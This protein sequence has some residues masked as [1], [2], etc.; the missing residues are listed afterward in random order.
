MNTPEWVKNATFYHIYPLGLLNA[1][2]TNPKDG[3]TSNRLNMLLPWLDHI[4]SLGL[5]A[6]YM[7]PLFESESHGYDTRDYF[8]VDRRLGS[9][10][11]LTNF[12]H[13]IHRR[14][15][16]IILDGVFNHSGRSFWA[17]EDLRLKQQE[18]QYIDW[19]QDL[20]F[21][22]SNSLGDPFQYQTWNGYSSL[23]KF[24]LSNANVRNYLIQAAHFWIDTFHID[25]LRLDAADQV[26]IDFWEQLR[27][28]LVESQPE[29][30]LMGEIVH[31]D[32]RLWAND[33]HL[34]SVTNYEAHKGLYSSFNDANFFE[35]AYTFNR[36]FGTEGIYRDLWLYN[37]VDNHDVDR[38]ASQLK[39]KNHLFP[40]YALLF[41]MP[42][43]PSIYYGSEWGLPGKRT[44]A[45]DEALRPSLDIHYIPAELT[46]PGLTDAIR[47]FVDIRQTHPAL[48]FGK[49]RQAL[50]KSHQFGFWREDQNQSVLVIINSANEPV[51]VTDLPVPQHFT[52]KDPFN[53]QDIAQITSEKISINIPPCWLRMIVFD[54]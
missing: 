16:H 19:Y 23:P 10:E 12:C 40:L 13:E 9:N 26:P 3:A 21:G 20:R 43:I 47:R 33:S 35:I 36:Q 42:G 51:Q 2:R 53:E 50:V 4:Q 54:K 5:N 22:Q 8:N 7:G 24:N 25:G 52:W 37:F 17:F 27:S 31:G 41:F 6:I 14:E 29:F 11:D 15:M 18:S 1:P 48:R 49:Y 39:Y 32:Y 34:H 28:S 38:I 44:K 30:W 45:S 46:L